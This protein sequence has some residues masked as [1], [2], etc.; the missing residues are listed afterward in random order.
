M[1]KTH[2]SMIGLFSSNSAS[3]ISMQSYDNKS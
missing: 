3:V 1:T 2:K